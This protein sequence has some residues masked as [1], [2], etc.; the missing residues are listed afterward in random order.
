MIVLK[1][2][3]K[4]NILRNFQFIKNYIP[5]N[6]LI[7]QKKRMKASSYLINLLIGYN[8]TA[9]NFAP[10]IPS[11]IAVIS[12]I[13][14]HLQRA[15]AFLFSMQETSSLGT[16]AN[17]AITQIIKMFQIQYLEQITPLNYEGITIILFSIIVLSVFVKVWFLIL[18]RTREQRITR[19]RLSSLFQ[20]VIISWTLVYEKYLLYI[21]VLENG[22]KVFS[23][24]GVKPYILTFAIFNLTCMLIF[25]ILQCVF[26][27]GI[28]YTNLKCIPR[29]IIGELIDIIGF[30]IIV[31]T[32]DAGSTASIYIGLVLTV[33]HFVCL[34]VAPKFV[35]GLQNQVEMIFHAFCF[36]LGVDILLQHHVYHTQ[37]F[38][39]LLIAAFIYWGLKSIL[40]YRSWSLLRQFEN[41]DL[42]KAMVRSLPLIFEEYF[43]NSSLLDSIYPILAY[44]SNP[45]NEKKVEDMMIFSKEDCTLEDTHT[46]RRP[47]NHSSLSSRLL[48]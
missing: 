2:I 28:P 24:P 8:R 31:A 9:S 12:L 38:P 16:T 11:W 4:I 1:N 27:F 7:L 5:K 45:G 10:K 35:D 6:Q 32:K 48:T 26:L 30:L 3:C 33:L 19:E 40:R 13:I 29:N 37:D 17:R 44:R 39:F 25:R 20:L 41:P 18:V 14:Y 46:S 47:L 15:G 43:E 34:F 22:F 36:A 42:S 23:Q 21:P